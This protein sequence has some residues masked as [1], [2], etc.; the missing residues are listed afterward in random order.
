M[1][2]VHCNVYGIRILE[3]QQ[4]VRAFRSIN[5][6]GGGRWTDGGTRADGLWQIKSRCAPHVKHRSFPPRRFRISVPRNIGPDVLHRQP[7]CPSSPPP[8]PLSLRPTAAIVPK[9][10]SPAHPAARRPLLARIRIISTRNRTR[11]VC[12]QSEKRS[13]FRCSSLRWSRCWTCVPAV[14]DT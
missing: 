12:T 14:Q 1:R 5:G 4:R 10:D 6:R 11:L 3:L 2:V 9:T 13:G 7:L 8:P